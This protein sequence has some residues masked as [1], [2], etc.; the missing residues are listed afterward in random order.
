MATSQFT[1]TSTEIEITRILAAF[2][3]AAV[4]AQARLDFAPGWNVT[5]HGDL[6]TYPAVVLD[7]YPDTGR[8]KV[9]YWCG[10]RQAWQTGGVDLCR[11][12]MCDHEIGECR[13]CGTWDWYS[14]FDDDCR[15]AN[16]QPE[17][18]PEDDDYDYDPVIEA[19][20]SRFDDWR[21]DRR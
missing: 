17:P 20:W 8:A 18:A 1:T 16:C 13:V 7:V 14:A 5:I 3:C 15:C 19:A 6:A 10:V 11:L 2:Y 21:A 9:Q 12:E 4:R